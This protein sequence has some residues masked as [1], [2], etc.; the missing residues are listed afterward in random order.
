MQFFSVARDSGFNEAWTITAAVLRRLEAVQNLPEG[1]RRAQHASSR[2]KLKKLLLILPVRRFW[3]F[4]R[5][6]LQRLTDFKKAPTPRKWLL[7]APGAPRCA[8]QRAP[9]AEVR[10]FTNSKTAHFTLLLILP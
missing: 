10:V 6:Y 7:G 1:A 4:S 2:K 9:G 8:L 5:C 3:L